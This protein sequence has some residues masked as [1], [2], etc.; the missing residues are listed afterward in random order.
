M[1]DLLLNQAL[2]KLFQGGSMKMQDRL[3]GPSASWFAAATLFALIVSPLR[4]H[5]Q[6]L[7]LSTM[8]P[9]VGAPGTQVT[10]KGEK[11]GTEKGHS[12]VMFSGVVAT[13]NRWTKDAIVVT[14]PTTVV[15]GPAEVVVTIDKVK[16]D[17]PGVFTVQVLNHITPTNGPTGTA[18]TIS[19][20]GFG[21]TK[22]ASA[23]FFGSTPA[24]LIKRWSDS[25][26]I[27]VVP[28]P[29][30]AGDPPLGVNVNLGKTVKQVGTFML[31]SAA[32]AQ[33]TQPDQAAKPDAFAKPAASQGAIKAV[34]AGAP[35]LPTDAPPK[36]GVDKPVTAAVAPEVEVKPQPPADA[37]QPIESPRPTITKLDPTSGGAATP[38]TIT[39]AGFGSSPGTVDFGGLPGRL[40]KPS[41]WSPTSIVVQAP[42]LESGKSIAVPVRV[43]TADEDARVVAGFFIETSAGPTVT[44]IDPSQGTAGTSVTIT[45][46]GFGDV[47]G[48]ST[49]TIGGLAATVAK[50]ADWTATKIVASVGDFNSSKDVTVAVSVSIANKSGAPSVASYDNGF[51]ENPA[52]WGD[53]DDVPLGIR[54]VGGYEQGFQSSQASNSDA[55][56]AFYGRA[57]FVK[58]R[59]GPFYSV[60]L[61]TAP[62]ASGTY[63]VV[64]VLTNPSGQVTTQNLQT[65]G[66]AVDLTLGFEYQFKKLFQGQATLGAI[67]GGGFITPLQVNS[68]GAT[69]TMPNFGTVEC[70][71]L[72]TR[73]S[74]VLQSTPY[75]G[76]KPNTSTANTYCFSNNTG[77]TPAAIN[78]LEYAAPDQPN[79][80]PKWGVGLRLVNR[81]PGSTGKKQ[82]D[83]DNACER[84]YVDFTL[85]QNAS[86]TG[87]TLQHAV[88]NIDSIYP[89]PVPN[90]N[91][92][93][94]FGSISKRF[95]TLP[96]YLPPLVLATGTASTAPAAST[97]IL[98]LTQ[99]DR[100]FYR[101]GVGVSLNAIFSAL[102]PKPKDATTTP[103]ASAGGTPGG[104]K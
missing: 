83:Q 28:D 48:K 24:T 76:V 82:C 55:F 72:Q 47:Q 102:K 52:P 71:A 19:G 20:S 12:T 96:S 92:I 87:G 7:V 43:T 53:N 62:Q 9:S 18:V 69:F 101:V 16:E 1:I 94:L 58:N 103:S 29:G 60:R 54:F 90:M 80:F 51:T 17:Y 49:V 50:P 35:A 6:D 68:I 85:G 104:S 75:T 33:A 30:V 42:D 13:V 41:D 44:K 97:L 67:G 59:F 15:P 95:G 88:M 89:L 40:A 98:P 77:A 32:I 78:T 25:Q 21:P 66:S 14:V 65:V 11:F 22:G 61:Q 5:T 10:I 86:I 70:T 91:F 34:P 45:G 63:S 39:G 36:G 81:W 64:S 2:D 56:L 26:I 73:L 46:T 99:P 84:G 100:D 3:S 31:S 27:V 23:V 93:Y 4:L 8:S 38:V 74:T 37:Q 57:L 79:F